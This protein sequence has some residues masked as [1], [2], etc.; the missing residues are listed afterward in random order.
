MN[1]AYRFDFQALP[2]LWRS[3]VL[4]VCLFWKGREFTLKLCSGL[5]VTR[6]MQVA[7]LLDKLNRV[8]NLRF[9]ESRLL[10]FHLTLKMYFITAYRQGKD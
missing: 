2:E 8:V 1:K 6:L 9:A 7:P 10:K 3:Q 5:D 4:L